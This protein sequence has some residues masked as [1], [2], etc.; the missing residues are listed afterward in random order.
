MKTHFSP[1]GLT[2]EIRTKVLPHTVQLRTNFSRNIL[3]LPYFNFPKHQD[4]MEQIQKETQLQ[5]RTPKL[6]L[7]SFPIL[8]DQHSY[9]VKISEV[10]EQPMKHK[11]ES[12]QSWNWRGQ[13]CSHTDLACGLDPFPDAEVAKD[14]GQQEAQGQLPAQASQVLDAI[15]DLQDSPPAERRGS[16]APVSCQP[17]LAVG[18]TGHRAGSPGNCLETA[19]F[20]SLSNPRDTRLPRDGGRYQP[21]TYFLFCFH[22]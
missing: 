5:E 21:I 15:W 8:P 9:N 4:Y 3:S 7:R 18:T 16:L 10:T 6:L 20:F 22:F 19:Q 12:S 14:P 11:Q 2:L 13:K 17:Q 1:K